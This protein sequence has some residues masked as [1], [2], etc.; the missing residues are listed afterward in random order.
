MAVCRYRQ[1]TG[2]AAA[3]V[4]PPR[5][6]YVIYVRLHTH[7][8]AR[9]RARKAASTDGATKQTAREGDGEKGDGVDEGWWRWLIADC[10][11]L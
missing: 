10:S 9:A 3:R 6:R 8:H 2:G 4:T 5:S 11:L 1:C 7:T